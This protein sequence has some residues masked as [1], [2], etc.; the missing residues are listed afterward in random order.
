MNVSERIRRNALQRPG[1]VA[2]AGVQGETATYA[3][4][5]RTIDV[6][7]RRFV[8]LGLR[9]GQTAIVAVADHYRYLVLALALARIG[10]AHGPAILPAGLAALAIV[11]AG[12]TA[13]DGVRAVQVGSIWPR[14][15]GAPVAPMP[16]H[17]QPG[18]VFKVCPSSGTT[19]GRKFMLL[20]HE[21]AMRRIDTRLVPGLAHGDRR[22]TADARQACFAEPSTAYGFMSS[23]LVLHG[24]GTVLEPNV[25]GT[26][27]PLWLVRSRVNVMILAPNSLAKIVDVQP[28]LR[29]ANALDVVEVG[30][31]AL[32]AQL[33]AVAQQ[34]LTPR[35]FLNYGSTECGRVAGALAGDVVGRPGAV[36]YAYPGVEL[37][38]VDDADEPLPPGTEGV[39]AVRSAHNVPGYLGPPELS[40][41]AFRNGWVYPGDR[42]V[43]G[44][45][46][47]LTITGRVD[48]IINAGGVKVNLQAL[49]DAIMTLA[50]LREVA[51]FGAVNDAGET[52]VC[53]AIVPTVPINADAFH[54][55]CREHMGA[56][57]PVF[58]MH[59]ESLPR[60][61]NG[62]VLRT[63]LARIAR[64]AGRS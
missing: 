19:G 52:C 22:G 39:L 20:T 5:E 44:A 31:A 1:A 40:T 34:R 4:L 7:A 33:L 50:D 14:S 15:Y 53:A 17:D 32:P 6:L 63:E 58:T 29:G 38:V 10:V 30:G 3:D 43:L 46:G 48:D 23:L 27:I 12:E 21:V 60:N 41:H 24:G 8:D 54:A 28:S 11:D 59:M 2:Y 47:L 62:K 37:R 18:T 16:M 64:E 45:D 55:R 57:A 36:G 25:E 26:E 49:E 51:V 35:I 42:A 9:E 13:P 56:L 61:S